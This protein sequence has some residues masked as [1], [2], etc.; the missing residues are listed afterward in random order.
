M[1]NKRVEKTLG[2]ETTSRRI[3]LN[4][5]R[6]IMKTVDDRQLTYQGK[7]LK[8]YIR[9]YEKQLQV[10]AKIQ[11]IKYFLSRLRWRDLQERL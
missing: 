4:R 3:W 11:Q 7:K 6:E 8:D 9:P 10:Y 1:E 2:R 5:R